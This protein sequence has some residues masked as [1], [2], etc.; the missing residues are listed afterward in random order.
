MKVLDDLAAAGVPDSRTIEVQY[1]TPEFK[2]GVHTLA[3]IR[4][5]CELVERLG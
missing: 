3:E 4:K 1:D 5:S 2:R